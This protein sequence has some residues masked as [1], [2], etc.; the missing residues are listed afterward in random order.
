MSRPDIA[1]QTK[2]VKGV[3]QNVGL[4]NFFPMLE[5]VGHA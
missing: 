4:F 3:F 5:I 2:C 1:I